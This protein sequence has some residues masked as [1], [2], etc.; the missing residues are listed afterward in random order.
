MTTAVEDVAAETRERYQQAGFTRAGVEAAAG[1]A[2][3]AYE[4]ATGDG[5]D[6][7]RDRAWYAGHHVAHAVA[8]PCQAIHGNLTDCHNLAREHVMAFAYGVGSKHLRL[9]RRHRD[10][11]YRNDVINVSG[12]HAMAW[13]PQAS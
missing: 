5:E 8:P 10:K 11:F 12:E 1:A 4:E 6:E 7:A 2:A 9:C 3:A 13:H